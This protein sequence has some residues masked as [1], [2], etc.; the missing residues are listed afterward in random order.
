[1]GGHDDHGHAAPAAK[2]QGEA[3]TWQ[4]RTELGRKDQNVVLL[5]STR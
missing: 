3:S 5:L 1:M 2:T 4:G